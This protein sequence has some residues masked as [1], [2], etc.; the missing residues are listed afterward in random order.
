MNGLEQLIYLLLSRGIVC[1]GGF[2]AVERLT[3]T[4]VEIDASTW[5]ATR[6]HF[7]TSGFRGEFRA[8]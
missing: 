7:L 5:F 2:C 8:G 1:D 6:T 3:D 4:G